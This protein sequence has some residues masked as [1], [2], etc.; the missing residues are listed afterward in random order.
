MKVV[1]ECNEEVHKKFSKGI[2]EVKAMAVKAIPQSD[3]DYWGIRLTCEDERLSVRAAGKRYL[4]INLKGVEVETID[5]EE[6]DG[7]LT[8]ATAAV[9][10]DAI[11]PDGPA[12]RALQ[13]E[14]Q[15]SPGFLRTRVIMAQ[16]CG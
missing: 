15:N 12:Q 8:V 4:A 5:S 6:F 11:K 2:K 13:W 16:L 9:D 3:L 7:L 1:A 10:I 14:I